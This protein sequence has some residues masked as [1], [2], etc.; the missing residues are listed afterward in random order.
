MIVNGEKLRTVDVFPSMMTVPDCMVV[1]G[2]KLGEG[3]GEAKLY[4]ASKDVMREFYGLEGF[5][6]K[7]FL[8]KK[9]LI[10]YMEAIKFEYFT[11]TQNYAKSGEMPNLWTERMRKISEMDD[12][13]FFNVYDQTQIAGPRG[14]VNSKDNG[15][16]I[17]RELALPLVSYIYAEK[18]D[19]G[20]SPLFY[21]KLFVDFE[22]IWEKKNGPLVFSY[23]KGK[24]KEEQQKDEV[25]QQ[26]EKKSKAKRG[27]DGQIK[28]REKLLEQCPFCPFTGIADDRLLIASHIKPWVAANEK[29]KVDPY[30]GYMLSP[31]YDKLFDRGFI[32]FTENRHVIL[33]SMIA[34]R[35]WKQIKL[36][37]DTFI[38][39]LPMDDKR[40]EYLKYHQNNVFKGTL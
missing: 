28:Y 19:N 39:R 13:I 16:K 31:L 35:T 4:V 8:L 23:G 40:I 7:C 32:T 12:I 27:R 3:H 5:K 36:E 26:E 10:S 11:P 30:N 2:N 1:A 21:W 17:I 37:N 15:Y 9:D 25:I 18:L 24:I 14:Y 38:Q 33:S 29:E 6:A 20:D 22:A 34:P